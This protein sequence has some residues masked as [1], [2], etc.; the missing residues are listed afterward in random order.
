MA[1]PAPVVV[2]GAV[3]NCT[4]Q[5]TEDSMDEFEIPDHVQHLLEVYDL[6]GND[7]VE[8]FSMEQEEVKIN[9][10]EK[11]EDYEHDKISINL[12]LPADVS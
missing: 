3:A 9:T 4:A 6:P 5:V 8:A 2:V 12:M 1:S 7:Q 11:L 10:N